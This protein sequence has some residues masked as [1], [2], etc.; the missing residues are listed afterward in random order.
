MNKIKSVAI[1]SIKRWK[2]RASCSAGALGKDPVARRNEII[3]ER[4]ELACIYL[5]FLIIEL[6][7]G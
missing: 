6:S 7:Y 5:A 2:R 1:I 3:P 4:E